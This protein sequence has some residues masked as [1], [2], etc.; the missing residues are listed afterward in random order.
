MFYK[1]SEDSFYDYIEPLQTGATYPAVTDKDVKNYTISFP[2]IQKQKELIDTIDTLCKNAES[3][4]YNYEKTISLCD[5]LKQAL[6]RKA[7]NGEL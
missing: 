2:S 3:L 1:L 6:L 5:D 7:F 4:R